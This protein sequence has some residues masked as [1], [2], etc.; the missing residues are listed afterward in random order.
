MFRFVIINREGKVR[1]K[2]SPLKG[3]RRMRQSPQMQDCKPLRYLW[4]LALLQLKAASKTAPVPP[5][6]SRALAQRA[7]TSAGRNAGP[8]ATERPPEGL[9]LVFR[10]LFSSHPFHRLKADASHSES[11]LFALTSLQ[12]GDSRH[13][14]TAARGASRPCACA[15][16]PGSAAWSAANRRAALAAPSPAPLRLCPPWLGGW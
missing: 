8:D 10:P 15:A 16:P 9:T 1:P 4:I 3:S 12:L 6:P 11:L 5:H 14:S 7:T 2:A 13:F